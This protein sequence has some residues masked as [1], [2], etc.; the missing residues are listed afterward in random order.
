MYLS[1][2]LEKKRGKPSSLVEVSSPQSAL[3]AV[4]TE[5]RWFEECVCRGL[6]KESKKAQVFLSS[7]YSTQPTKQVFLFQASAGTSTEQN[8]GSR[9][10]QGLQRNL[11]LLRK[12][13]DRSVWGLGIPSAD[14]FLRGIPPGC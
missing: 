10:A 11:L 7:P 4:Y 2:S 3:M 13:Q 6:R 1:S 9:P 14:Q 5:C 12:A 8:W